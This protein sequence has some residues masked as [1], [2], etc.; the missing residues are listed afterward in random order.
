MELK[1]KGVGAV[2]MAGQSV[3]AKAA[4]V[5]FD[6]VLALPSLIVEV[7]DVLGSTG[8]IGN[9]KADIGTQGTD[10]NFDQDSSLSVPAFGPVAKAIEPPNETFGAQIFALGFLNPALGFFLKHRVGSN[11]D[12]IEGTQRLQ[13]P[14]D[15]W[16]C[17]AGIGP[18][19]DLSVGKALFKDGYQALKLLIDSRRGRGI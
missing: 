16:S 8:A 13:G 19:A 2:T 14:V 10:F 18:V 6:P 4:L 17:G 11:A 9:D 1:A 15:L 5:G 7:I 3:T 12:G